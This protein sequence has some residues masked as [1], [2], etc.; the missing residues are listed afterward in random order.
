[1]GFGSIFPRSRRLAQFLFT[2]QVEYWMLICYN[3][4]W[5]EILIL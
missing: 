5:N 3:K 2:I 4:K 1:M